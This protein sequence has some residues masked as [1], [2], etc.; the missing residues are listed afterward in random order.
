MKR[1][2]IIGDQRSR[3]RFDGEECDFYTEADAPGP[4]DYIVLDHVLQ[5]ADRGSVPKIIDFYKERLVGGGQ[6][7]LILP[8][9]EW[10]CKEIAKTDEPNPLAYIALYG[11]DAEPHKS[12]MTMFWM[13]IVAEELGLVVIKAGGEWYKA[14]LR[15]GDLEQEFQAQQN[16]LVA[17]RMPEDAADALS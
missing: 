1:V 10:A 17:T 13:R 16:V 6:L 2:L 5:Q 9:L 12:G 15:I 7:V 8:S 11:T 14:S 3:R 4:F